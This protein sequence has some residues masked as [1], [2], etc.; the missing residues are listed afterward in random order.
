MIQNSRNT[1]KRAYLLMGGNLGNPEIQFLRAQQLIRE[2]CGQVLLSSSLYVTAPW[3]PIEQNDFLNQALIVATPLSPSEL[4]TSLLQIEQDL[5][6]ERTV[7]MGPRL[8]DIDLLLLDDWVLD[9][10]GLQV[11]HPLLTERRF[12]LMPLAE[13]APH[14]V[15]PQTGK[16]MLAH[17][18]ACSD[19]GD[20]QKKAFRHE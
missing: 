14:L 20:V 3:G 19:S 13:I 1:F 16:T 6:R 10:P 8:L 2:R 5:G 9:V 17:L 4:M 15:H 18:I 7:K 12:A 11:P